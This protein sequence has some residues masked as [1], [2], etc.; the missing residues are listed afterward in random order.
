[1]DI[2]GDGMYRPCLHLSVGMECLVLTSLDI[3]IK[4]NI[5]LCPPEPDLPGC[6]M[7]EDPCWDIRRGRIIWFR[8]SCAWV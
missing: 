6:K 2:L 8:T 3:Y 4:S 5:T 7:E 1:M